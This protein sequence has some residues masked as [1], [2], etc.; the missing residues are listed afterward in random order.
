MPRDSALVDYYRARAAEYEKVYAKPERQA[1]LGVLHEIVPA[2]FVGRHVLD[3][4]CGTGYWTR[5]IGARAT[6]VVAIDLAVETLDIARSRQPVESAVEFRLADAFDLASVAGSVD[7]AFAGFWWSHLRYEDLRRF[8]AG[9]HRCLPRGSPVFILDNRYVDGS[10]RPISR[11][12]VDGNSYQNRRLESGAEYEVLKNFPTPLEVRAAII[13]SGGSEP[14]VE[15][16]PYY[17][18]AT[19]SVAAAAAT[20]PDVGTDER[21]LDG[22]QQG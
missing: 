19:Y 7:A 9:L 12:D 3:I 17:W 20:S 1:D 18:Y 15:E 6:S 4:A 22:G 21:E 10:S 11:T 2:F 16:L 5:L 14:A 13:A 8:L